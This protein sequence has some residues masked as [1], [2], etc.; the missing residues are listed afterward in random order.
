MPLQDLTPQLRTRLNRMEK[1]VGWFILLATALL[2]F[3]FGYYVYKTAERRGWFKIKAPYFTYARSG[4]GFAVGDQI[5]LMGFAA[6]QIT[7]VIPM[8]AKWGEI[9]DHNVYLEFEVTEPNYGYLWTEGSLVDFNEAGF[10]G[11]R[12]LDLT[13]GT[14][15]YATYITKAFHDQM[16]VADAQALPHLDKWR[17]AQNVYEGTN[18][19]AKAWQPLSTSLLEKIAGLIGTNNIRAIDS[20]SE[21]HRLT[22]VWNETGRYYERF[23]KDSKPYYLS[24]NEPPALTERASALVAQIEKALPSFLNLTN[25]LTVVLSNSAR[26]T[27][28]L[29]VVAEDARPVMTNLSMITAQL[30]DPHGSLG[31]WVIPTNLNQQLETTLRAANGTLT[32]VNTNLVALAD[33]VGRSLDNLANITSNLNNQVQANSNILTHV[34]EIVVHSDQFVQG[35]KRFWLFR[36]QFPVAKTNAPD[37]NA[38][39]WP[40]TGGERK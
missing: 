17:L 11:K 35:L 7:K 24:G 27:S 13:K 3:G 33:G 30:R 15:G 10:L 34:S 25:E 5:K 26:L 22:A 40:K 31:E 14:A 18:L 9:T 12:E 16:T 20:S 4:N 19:A 38:P 32:N 21:K 39:V 28:N 8:P 6:G 2:V 1:A 37:G 23:T 36:H 29:N